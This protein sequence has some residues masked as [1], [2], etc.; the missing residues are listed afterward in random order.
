MKCEAQMRSVLLSAEASLLDLRVVPSSL[1]PDTPWVVCLCP[2]LLTDEDSG[3]TG[4]GP[5]HMTSDTVSN[6]VTP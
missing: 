3:P 6:S 1:H 5:T 2:D 4:P